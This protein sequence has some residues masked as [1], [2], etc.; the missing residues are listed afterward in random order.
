MHVEIDQ[1]RPDSIATRLYCP[2]RSNWVSGR[3]TNH[4]TYHCIFVETLH[5]LS[6][7]ELRSQTATYQSMRNSAPGTNHTLTMAESSPTPIQPTVGLNE[8]EL[9]DF[10]LSDVDRLI[11]SMTDEEYKLHDWDE[12]REVI[13]KLTSAPIHRLLFLL[14]ALCPFLSFTALQ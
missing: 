14:H 10:P 13:G 2:T 8:K 12:L 5:C 1:A 4:D 6:K 3:T 7:A 11:L 9:G